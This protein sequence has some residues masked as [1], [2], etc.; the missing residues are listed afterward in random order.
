MEK[1]AYGLKQ[2]PQAWFDRFAKAIQQQ[3]YK[4]A[5]IDHTLFYRHKDSKIKILIIYVD[6]IMLT[7]DD[8]AEME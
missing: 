1:C 2:S 6:N 8:M 7:G 4:Q 3:G 5:H